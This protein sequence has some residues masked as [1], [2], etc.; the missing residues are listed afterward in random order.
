M[1]VFTLHAPVP[2]PPSSPEDTQRNSALSES[3]IKSIGLEIQSH[4]P[5]ARH[6]EERASLADTL[7]KAIS[8]EIHTQL[9]TSMN[10]NPNSQNQPKESNNEKTIGVGL[11]LSGAVMQGLGKRIG[12]AGGLGA[13]LFGAG[14]GLAGRVAE[15]Y[16]KDKF[17]NP[18]GDA[19]VNG[20]NAFADFYRGL[21]P[22]PTLPNKTTAQVR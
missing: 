20:P 11:T 10:N 1:K 6:P 14:L 3:L 21:V 15:E 22:P 2:P 7:L 9:S 8:L 5:M 4:F 16:G 19:S 18:S 12:S 13:K 17:S